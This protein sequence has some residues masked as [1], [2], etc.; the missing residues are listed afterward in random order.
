[1]ITYRTGD[2]FNHSTSTEKYDSFR[3]NIAVGDT[4]T[5]VT[6]RDVNSFT[7]TTP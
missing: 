3:E 4:L 5:V 1:M 2:Q 7:R 6:A